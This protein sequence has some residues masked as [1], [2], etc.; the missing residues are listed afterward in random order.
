MNVTT[1]DPTVSYW[2]TAKKYCSTV[3][4]IGG[5]TPSIRRHPAQYARSWSRPSPWAIL[6]VQPV[7]LVGTST[8]FSMPTNTVARRKMQSTN[9][10]AFYSTLFG[11]RVPP[12]WNGS[13]W[14][15]QDSV[16]TSSARL[17]SRFEE[18]G[19]QAAKM[20]VAARSIVE[21]IDIFSQVSD[22]QLSVLVDL[23][24]DPLFLQAAE[25]RL[26][27]GIVP[28]V[29]FSAHTRLEMIRASESPPRIAAVL[30]AL[31]GVD[32]RT[33]RSSSPNRQQHGVEHELAVN[34]RP[35]SPSHD[36]ARE[37]I[38]DDG[39]V[40]PALPSPNVG[41]VGHPRGVW[42][43]G[44][45]LSLQEIRDKDRG[46]A[47]GPAPH[48]ITVQGTQ[49]GVAHQPRNAVLAASLASLTQVEEDARGTI[50]AVARDERRPN[51]AQ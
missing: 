43:R 23:F 14:S 36:H 13:S 4:V 30:G 28:A 25:K 49:I 21:G 46:L 51:Q 31:I 1:Y 41:D 44:G 42:P 37:Q 20:A 17:V 6:I 48:A 7:M 12:N 19:T 16:E 11:S 39:Q 34:G 33:S 24:L 47:N 38:H 26:G 9:Y 40:Q 32:Q 5:S 29:A 18:L 35:S 15:S 8:T 10:F 3:D 45:E 22:R 2:A 27:D 50:D